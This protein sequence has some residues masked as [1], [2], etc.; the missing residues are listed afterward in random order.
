[1]QFKNPEILYALL[2]LIIPI[3][4]HLFQLRRF[5]K[6]EFTNLRFL[7]EV[8]LQTRKSS[9]LKKW[10]VLASRLLMLACIIL[11]FAQPFQ[12]KTTVSIEKELVI[13]LDNSYSMQAKSS[14][15]ELLKTAVQQL[16][17]SPHLPESINWFSNHQTFRQAGPDDFKDQLVALPYSGLQPT[18]EEILLQANTL[19]SK[20][21]ETDKTLLII[22]DFQEINNWPTEIDYPFSV[23]AVPLLPENPANLS[24]DSVYISSI[25]SNQ[26]ELTAL[27]KNH[28][29][30]RTDVPVSFYQD[31]TL[32]AKTAVDLPA[33]GSAKAVFEI[34]IQQP[35]IGKVTLSDESLLFDNELLFNL[36]KTAAVKVLLIQ[37]EPVSFLNKIFTPDEF[38]LLIFQPQAID[39]NAIAQ[40]NTIILNQ[41]A[42]IPTSLQ[43]I[44]Q[45]FSQQGGTLVVIPHGEA[46]PA[47]YNNLLTSLGLPAFERNVQAENQITTIQFSHPLYVNVFE[48]QITNFQFP[49]VNSYFTLSRN[50]VAAL[51]FKDQRPFL[52][53]SSKN[54]L[55]TA[56][57]HTDHSNF[58]RS[59]LVVPTFYRMAKQSLPL[60]ELYYT[61]GKENQ[62]AV[63]IHLAPNQILTLQGPDTQLIPL[64]QN[65]NNQV[66]ITTYDSPEQAGT[67]TLFNDDNPLMQVS[68]NYDRRESLTRYLDLTQM[69]SLSV[70]R[71]IDSFLDDYSQAFQ[72]KQ[73]WKWFVIFALCF[74]CIETLLLKFLRWTYSL[75]QPPL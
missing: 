34:D 30:V 21:T 13:Y 18:Y 8:T 32:V 64:Q 23:A 54:Y 65:T 11:A 61:L 9:Q 6:T 63:P 53:Q 69:E 20:Q 59:P 36:Q 4:I 55:F 35:F 52:I 25:S 62:Y 47:D 38:E 2:L 71:E 44:L 51:A 26:A 74:L 33:S 1:M 50:H 10:L 7:K 12:A 43:T 3:L 66:L 28:G 75:N 60:P 49:H 15:G 19:F 41:L 16:I 40:Q 42:E 57:L 72:A 39:Y 24:V 22:S 70:H 29:S 27:L 68:Y 46:Q 14:S 56:A 73:L 37:D 67:Y 45:N 17:E 58:I 31:E 5:K 48:N